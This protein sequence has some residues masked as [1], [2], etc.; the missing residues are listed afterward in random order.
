[1]GNRVRSESGR[2]EKKSSQ[3]KRRKEG[4]GYREEE[5]A[6]QSVMRDEIA[7]TMRLLGVTRLDQLGPHLVCQ[8]LS[9]GSLTFH[10]N[11]PRVLVLEAQIGQKDQRLTL[12]S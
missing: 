5:E 10:P 9:L 7:T 4:R 12:I 3:E 6:D 1:M 2:D 11:L 8:Y